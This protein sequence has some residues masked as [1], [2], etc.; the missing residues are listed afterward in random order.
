MIITDIT[1][2]VLK[3]PEGTPIQDATILAPRPGIRSQLFVHIHTDEGYEGL[4]MAEATPGTRDVIEAALKPVLVGKDP[5]DIEY[6]WNQMFWNVRGFGRKGVAFCAISAVDIGLW[7][8]KGKILG[9]PLYKLLGAYTDSVPIYGSGGWTNFTENE[10]IAEME[11]YVNSGIPRVKMKVGKDFGRSEVEDLKRVEAVRKAVGD[12]VTI[13]LDANNGY[14]RKQA[15]YMSKEFEQFQIG[16]LEDPL[17]PDDIPGM[18]TISKSTSIPIAT[19]EHEYTKYGFRDLV[20][21]GG[22]DIVQPDIGRVG[23]VTEWMKV[24]H[25]CQSFNLPIAPHAMQLPHLHVACAI[26]NLKVVEY[27]NVILEGDRIWYTDFPQQQN[28]MWS[29]FK[30]RPGLGLELDH[31]S[32]SKYSV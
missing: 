32:V 29:P 2:T 7:D 5:L 11:G 19:G 6:L 18:A 17:I 12:N 13:F 24:A 16:W 3:I 15:I 22:A 14:Y 25:L 31:Y 10:L 8:L 4:G 30:D 1:T 28:G 21:K 27:M 20:E 23:G 26:P 9:L